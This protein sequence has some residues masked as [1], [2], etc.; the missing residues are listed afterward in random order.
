METVVSARVRSIGATPTQI[1]RG[2]PV[3]GGAKV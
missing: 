3:V 2:K 1:K